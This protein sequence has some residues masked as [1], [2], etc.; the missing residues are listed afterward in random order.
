MSDE[1]QNVR[2]LTALRFIYE[3]DITH[4][5]SGMD[6][7]F[8]AP[9][10]ARVELSSS[11]RLVPLNSARDVRSDANSVVKFVDAGFSDQIVFILFEISRLNE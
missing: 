11:A 4:I 9:S 3:I 8:S 2:R 6:L 5:Q 10:S 7:L 1:E